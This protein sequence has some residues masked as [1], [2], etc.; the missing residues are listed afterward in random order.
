[1][2]IPSARML[3]AALQSRSCILPECARGQGLPR[4]MAE[5]ITT[6]MYFGA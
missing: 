3:I 5:K 1:M 6:M 2:R 4:G